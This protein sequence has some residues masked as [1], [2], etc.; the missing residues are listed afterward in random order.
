MNAEEL[1]PF[2]EKQGELKIRAKLMQANA[3]GIRFE[4]DF[5]A[6]QWLLTKDEERRKARE[7]EERKRYEETLAAAVASAKAANRS[8]RWTLGAAVA[9]AI[10]AAASWAQ[11]IITSPP[12][13]V[14]TAVAAPAPPGAAPARLPR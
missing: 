1:Y 13:P 8:A 7:A 3:T 4:K 9:S 2:F 5:E 10:A 6:Q 12:A 11:I 14:P